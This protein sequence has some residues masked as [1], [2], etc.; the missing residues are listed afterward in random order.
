[1]LSFLLV[2]FFL[3][4]VMVSI[5]KDNLEVIQYVVQAVHK[6]PRSSCFV[7]PSAMLNHYSLNIPIFYFHFCVWAFCL[8][9]CLYTACVQ[10][11]PVP[12]QGVGSPV[13]EITDSCEPWCVSGKFNLGPL[14]KQPLFLAADPLLH[15]PELIFQGYILNL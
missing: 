1:M 9:V 5:T 14:E 8:R 10:C 15:F 3:F 6:S 2:S 4:F 11:L 7:L 13:T 12:E